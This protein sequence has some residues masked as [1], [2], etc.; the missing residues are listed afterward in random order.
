MKIS[1]VTEPAKTLDVT[2]EYD[3]V[4]AGGGIAGVAAAVAAARNG[5]SVCLLER[6]FSL[7]GLATLGN[8]TVYLPICDG[9]G[10]QVMAGL[11]EELLKLSVADLQHDNKQARFLG[12]PDCWKDGGDVTQRKTQRY[13][14]SFNPSSYLLALEQLVLEAG[15]DLLYDTRVCSVLRNVDRITH[16]VIENKSCRSAIAC[17]TVIDATGDADICQLA[18]ER[19]ESLDNNVLTGWFY[20][21]RRDGL[22]QTPWTNKC[23]RDGT[24]DGTGPF[25]RGD[26]ARDIT[27]HVIES[28]KVM[29]QKLQEQRSESPDDDIQI[30]NPPT[31]AC[32]RMTRRLVGDFSL[33]WGHIHQWFDDA[34]GLTGD[35]R[36][37]GPVFAVPYR[38]LTGVANRNLLAVGRCMSADTTIWDLTRAIPTCA[39]TGTAAGVSASLAID[40]GG[41]VLNIEIDKLQSRLREQGALLDPELVKPAQV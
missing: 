15:V 21:L 39:L 37:R 29:R 22:K 24:K 17:K 12:V 20:E 31:I 33:G 32:L 9:M 5:A 25:F 7:G 35:W 18:G 36:K 30:F 16:L 38:A 26:N 4:V 2:G 10:R 41:D 28:R 34:V 8:V 1:Q 40:A 23:S 27:S 11:P 6:M 19:T 13:K 14:T 3:V